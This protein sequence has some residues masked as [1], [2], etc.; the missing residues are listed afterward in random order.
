MLI[1]LIQGYAHGGTGTLSGV[2]NAAGTPVRKRVVLFERRSNRPVRDA[3]SAANGSYSFTNL[4]TTE[5]FYTVAFDDTATYTPSALIEDM[6]T[7]A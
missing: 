7:P 1:Q 6:E 2:V 5:K 4:D 3:I